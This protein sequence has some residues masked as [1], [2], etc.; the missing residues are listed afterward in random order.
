MADVAEFVWATSLPHWLVEIPIQMPVEKNAPPI[1]VC[2]GQGKHIVG[3]EWGAVNEDGL[4]GG[5]VHPVEPNPV[6][7]VLYTFGNLE[8]YKCQSNG[9][10][11]LNMHAILKFGFVQPAAKGKHLQKKW[12]AFI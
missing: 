2:E 8:E 12:K 10:Q 7:C 9:L 6:P 4:I 11:P 5:V 3:T 1:S